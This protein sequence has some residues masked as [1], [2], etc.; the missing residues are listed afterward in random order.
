MIE[1]YDKFLSDYYSLG[2]LLLELLHMEQMDVIYE[3]GF[4]R[5]IEDNIKTRISSAKNK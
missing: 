4:R 1:R 3:K 5:I 2:A